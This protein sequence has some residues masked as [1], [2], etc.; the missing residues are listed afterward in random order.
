MGASDPG[1]KYRRHRK[2]LELSFSDSV[3]QS[4]DTEKGGGVCLVAMG[5]QMSLS[6]SGTGLLYVK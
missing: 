4:A 1:A 5:T 6:D 3:C 2:L